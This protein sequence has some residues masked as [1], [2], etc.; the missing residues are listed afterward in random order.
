LWI[1]EYVFFGFSSQYYPCFTADVRRIYSILELQRP[2][3]TSRIDMLIIRIVQAPCE[4]SWTP[5]PGFVSYISLL[6]SDV[7]IRLSTARHSTACNTI[8]LIKT[9]SE[10]RTSADGYICC[11]SAMIPDDCYL[12]FSRIK[13]EWTVSSLI[14][15][16]K[17]DP[18]KLCCVP[19]CI[20][21][22]LSD[23]FHPTL[24][25]HLVPWFATRTRAHRC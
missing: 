10:R 3:A 16:V 13:L 8:S 17:P 22:W 23:L 18:I 19:S 1:S 21:K 4:P 2:V 20:T 25:N 6:R 24:T 11:Y 12:D 9:C 7:F 15:Y 14:W 5:V